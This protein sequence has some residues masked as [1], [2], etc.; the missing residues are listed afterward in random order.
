MKEIMKHEIEKS[1][2]LN[3]YDC[4]IIMYSYVTPIPV[5]GMESGWR[6]GYIGIPK[7]SKFFKLG[8]NSI[9][10][11]FNILVHGDF[12]FADSNHDSRFG[13]KKGLWWIGFDCMHCGDSLSRWTL[14]KV[15][16]ELENTTKQMRAIE[17][18]HRGITNE[19]RRT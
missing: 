9:N 5:K 17:R 2:K 18:N 1:L 8:Y 3:G 11:K 14:N 4:R 13:K 15:I 19:K 6:C 16:E 7:N 10:E 12:T